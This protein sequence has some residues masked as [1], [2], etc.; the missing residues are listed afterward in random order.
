MHGLHVCVFEGLGFPPQN[1]SATHLAKNNSSFAL[2]ANVIVAFGVR[3]YN[4][5]LLNARINIALQHNLN[6][7]IVFL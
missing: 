5:K 1:P 4:R 2:F 6:S 7:S 3:L